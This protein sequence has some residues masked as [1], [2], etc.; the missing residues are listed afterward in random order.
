MFRVL[1]NQHY[2]DRTNQKLRSWANAVF[3]NRGVCGQA[4]PSFP[5]P[6]PVNPYFFGSRPDV[7]DEFARKRLL[8]RLR[9]NSK[10]VSLPW[11]ILIVVSCKPPV[12]CRCG[13]LLLLKLI[14]LSSPIWSMKVWTQPGD[15]CNHVSTNSSGE[16]GVLSSVASCSAWSPKE[17][18][19]MMNQEREVQRLLQS[20]F[21]TTYIVFIFH[22]STYFFSRR[23]I[24]SFSEKA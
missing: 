22:C 17:R 20:W 4:V 16:R 5:S 1:S 24:L 8:R 3:Q 9:R 18:T 6:S 10:F 2:Q 19:R 7:L 15:V 23:N 12:D 11:L 21:K 14:T 13:S